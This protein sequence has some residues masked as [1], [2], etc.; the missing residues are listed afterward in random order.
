MSSSL[1]TQNPSATG[2]T[3]H[4]APHSLGELIR[5]WQLNQTPKLSDQALVNRFPQLGHT[6][7]F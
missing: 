5:T 6:R 4:Q 1:D 2:E 3:M 7:T